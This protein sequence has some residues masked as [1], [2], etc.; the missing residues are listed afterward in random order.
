MHRCLGQGAS[1][2]CWSAA[3][4]LG[5]DVFWRFPPPASGAS[6]CDIPAHGCRAGG[7]RSP[8]CAAACNVYAPSGG[9]TCQEMSEKEAQIPASLTA[10]LPR[11]CYTLHGKCPPGRTAVLA[12]FIHVHAL[13]VAQS[14][15]Q[16]GIKRMWGGGEIRL[17]FP[18]T[19]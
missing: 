13:Q 15:L 18:L 19:E 7:S 8:C 16:G 2:P 12:G 3:G 1:A 6:A 11:P 4:L 9:P 17:R 10:C 14:E 5:V